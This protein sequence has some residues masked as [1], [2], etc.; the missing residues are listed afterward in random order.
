MARED[1]S[2]EARSGTRPGE[3]AYPRF[4]A[5][6]SACTEG[7]D[8][9]FTILRMRRRAS[10]FIGLFIVGAIITGVCAGMVGFLSS[11]ATTGVRGA[12]AANPATDLSLGITMPLA[13]D[14]AEQERV[15]A[16]TLRN[17]LPRRSPR[18]SDLD[19]IVRA[20]RDRARPSGCRF[21]RRRHPACRG[22][23]RVSPGVRRADRGRSM[24]LGSGRGDAAGGC[25]CRTGSGPRRHPVDR[26]TR[27]HRRRHVAAGRGERRPLDGRRAVDDR[28]RWQHRG[29]DHH[30]SVPL[31]HSGR[32]ALG[33]LGDHARC[34]PAATH[35]PGG[36]RSCVGW[37]IRCPEGRGS[38][39][40]RPIRSVPRRGGRARRTTRRASDRAPARPRDPR[41]DRGTH[42]LGTRRPHDPHQGDR[43]GAAV[44]TG[45]DDRIARTARRRRSRRGDRDRVRGGR[46]G[47]RAAAV[48]CGR[49]GCR[50]I[51]S[52]IRLVGSRRRDRGDGPGLRDSRSAHR[53]PGALCRPR[54]ARA[55]V[56]RRGRCRAAPHR[57]RT[58]HLA[59]PPVRAGQREG[60]QRHERG[61][62]HGRRAGPHPRGRGAPRPLRV[63]AAR[64]RGRA[65]GD[66]HDRHGTRRAGR[67]P[68]HRSRGCDHRHDRAR[69][70]AADRRGGLQRHLERGLHPDAGAAGRHRTAA[71]GR[72][73]RDRA[74]RPRSCGGGDGRPRA[75]TRAHRVVQHRRRPGEPAGRRPGG[76]RRPD[77][78]RR[79]PD[80]PRRPVD[81]DPLAGR[82][83]PSRRS[84]HGQRRRGVVT[85]HRRIRLAHRRLGP[86][87]EADTHHVDTRSRHRRAALRASETVA[88]G[89]DRSRADRRR[90]RIRDGRIPHRRGIGHDRRGG[91]E[92][93]ALDAG[94]LP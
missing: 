7:T 1:P 57:C 94:R 82:R 41:R 47:R 77:G 69:G 62:D 42:P 88:A 70:G 28:S 38:G 40:R 65:H 71:H 9:L 18:D 23:D 81:G 3:R 45:R 55:G 50:G 83:D 43:D 37:G 2:P 48:E 21:G 64:G 56:R 44:V 10:L 90:C 72:V 59:A 93:G 54:G 4:N 79:G 26:R 46:G 76:D 51:R 12:L 60:H 17:G 91:G 14:A 22:R 8:S 92:P 53:R 33:D 58:L 15:T 87:R 67:V 25:R 24:G 63:P 34:G 61:P 39:H 36:D 16:Q 6:R 19:R 11:S 66:A 30:R 52:R 35:R 27:G 20:E 13:S 84:D 32:G 80:R 49:D 74:D 86:A 5:H 31:E 75:R 73:R 68:P 85:G 78:G 29:A 89:R